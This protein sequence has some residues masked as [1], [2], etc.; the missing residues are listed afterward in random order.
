MGEYFVFFPPGFEKKDVDMVVDI[1]DV[2]EQKLDAAR[3]HTSQQ[4]DVDRVTARWMRMPKEEWF[5]VTS[6]TSSAFL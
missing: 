4:G 2:F 6:R 1:E 5:L 3:C